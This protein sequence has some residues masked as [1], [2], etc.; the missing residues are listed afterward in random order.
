VVLRAAG[1]L[2]SVQP[3]GIETEFDHEGGGLARVAFSPVLA[4]D[5]IPYF[6]ASVSAEAD[7]DESD[8][9]VIAVRDGKVVV[10]PWLRLG[11]SNISAETL[12]LVVLAPLS[13]LSDRVTSGS[14][15]TA[16]DASRS[17]ARNS[18]SVTFE[19]VI[20]TGNT[21]MTVACAGGV[22][23]GGQCGCGHAGERFDL[24]AQCSRFD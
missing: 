12:G 8:Q 18:R 14:P 11:A 5:G 1:C 17:S 24:F 7:A 2:D 22:W 20:S 21:A 16:I 23:S 9:K 19:P 13:K 4:P 10:R 6:S 3:K 15:T